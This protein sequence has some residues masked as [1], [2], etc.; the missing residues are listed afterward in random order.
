MFADED[1]PYTGPP[2]DDDA[3]RR[4]EQLLGVRLPGSYVA[5]LR[6]RNGGRLA[7]RCY[8]TPF[9]TSWAPDHFEVLR[10]RG[11]G[12]AEG[13]ETESP[14]LIG[15][16]DYPDIGVVICD[17]PSGGHDTVMLDYTG[18]GPLDEPAVAYIDED[19]VPRRVAASFGEFLARLQPAEG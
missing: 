12:G 18:C 11:I 2:L 19:R 8:P 16:W 9:P 10:L 7:R 15:E 1:D 13:I 3:V 4:A 14:Y 5:A 6:I 17:T